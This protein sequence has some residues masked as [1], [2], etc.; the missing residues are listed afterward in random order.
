MPD[1]GERTSIEP[2]PTNEQSGQPRPVPPRRGRY[3]RL[4]A[5]IGRHPADLIRMAVAAGFV[6]IFLWIARAPGVNPVESAIFSELERLPDWSQRGWTALTWFGWWPGIA[7]ASGVALYA[8]RVRMAV[9]LAAASV[10][11]WL[12]AVLLHWLTAPRLV[13]VG[14]VP[15]LL[16]QPDGGVFLFPSARAAVIAAL[17]TSASPY[18]TR[19]VRHSGWAAVALV[20]VA[21]VF[22]GNNLPVGAVAGAALGWGTGTFYHLVLGA[23]GRKT[24]ED[25]VRMA[26]EEAGL[27]HA[28]IAP[29]PRRWLRPYAYDITTLTG[30]HLQM[31][32]V[33]RLHRLAGPVY[34]LRR[35]L[36]SVEDRHEPGRLATPR[37]E[38]EHEAYMTLLAERAGIGVLPVVLVGEIEH[39]PPFLLRRRV[40]GRRLSTLSSDVVDDA[41]LGRIWHVVALL[42]EHRLAHHGLRAQNILIDRD[43]RPRIIDFTFSR[44]GGP[45]GQVPQDVAEMLV[46][47][48]SVVGVQRALASAER[49]VP[50]DTLRDAL[51]HLQ[52]L[53]LRRRLRRQLDEDRTTLAALRETL[54]DRIGQPPPRFHSPVRPVTLLIMLFFGAAIYLL[55]PQLSSL[56][57]VRSALA[58]A[59]WWWIGVAIATGFLGVVASGVTIMGSSRRSLPLGKTMAV[60]LAAAFTGRT[61]AAGV[62]FFGVNIIYLERLGLRRTHAVG[63]V[64][65]NR[66]V[67]GVVTGVATA[68][69]ILVIGD[70]V[71]V[72]TIAIPTGWPVYVIAALLVG[73]LVFL[74]SPVGRRRVWRPL[75]A[76]LRELRGDLLPVFRQ[77]IRAL[78][79]LGGSVVFLVLQAI[80][81]AATLAAFQPSF[82][83]LPVLAVYVVGSTLGQ[84]VP[85]PGGLGAVE[86]ATVA[87]LTAIGIGPTNAVA[88]VLTSRA[89]T[90]WLPVLPGL[91]AFRLLQHRDII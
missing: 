32:V 66:A 25:A 45:S 31:K 73:I 50:S 70:A 48:A 52:W 14:L 38:L 15:L 27:P 5:S 76:Q 2:V 84:L 89:L 4:R 24:S 72:G 71:P 80:G 56:G 61:T 51:P 13:P 41:V 86:A 47:L 18:L 12:L 83:I 74:A 30:E 85:T 10:S 42:G 16:R 65:L 6:L 69:G 68:L 88:A 33:R 7:A 1:G 46:T 34:R 40:E 9:S 60:Q 53:A 82:P 43:N 37:H 28:E 19:L 90:F 20:A 21:E 77:P 17:V 29:V 67:V 39:G 64:L 44:A 54:A 79:L 58:R 35:L 36:A 8:G 3:A 63:V 26:L 49:A 55:L 59:D 57:E 81:L 11:A 87:G 23:P 22:L 75:A 78:Q 91:A 62:G